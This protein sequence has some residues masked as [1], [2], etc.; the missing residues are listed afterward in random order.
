M[1]IIR[2]RITSNRWQLQEDAAH[3]SKFTCVCC[4]YAC[5]GNL[6]HETSGELRPASN[7]FHFFVVVLFRSQHCP[8][9]NARID[10]TS[11]AGK[12]VYSLLPLLWSHL[13]LTFSPNSQNLNSTIVFLRKNL[14]LQHILHCFIYPELFIMNSWRQK[15]CIGYVYRDR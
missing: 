15:L 11:G 1:N 13:D 4:L 3:E 12:N 8:L 6:R 2:A 9:V 14:H 5:R 7:S 10:K